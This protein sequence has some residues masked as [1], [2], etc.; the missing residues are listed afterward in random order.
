ML[1]AIVIAH[2]IVCNPVKFLET[3]LLRIIEALAVTV[4]VHIGAH[5]GLVVAEEKRGRVLVVRREVPPV[6]R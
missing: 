4:V 5:V 1:L 6:P 3:A 2:I